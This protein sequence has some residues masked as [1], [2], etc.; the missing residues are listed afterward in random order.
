MELRS[1]RVGLLVVVLAM[2]AAAC[3]EDAT[4]PEGGGGTPSADTV[5]ASHDQNAGDLLAEICTRGEIR[6]STD[7]AYP[8][9]S[10]LNPET[11]EYEGF[12]IDVA[13]ESPTGSA[14]RSCGRRPSG[15]S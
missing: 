2:V 7:P 15:R 12:D 11:G 10:E 4:P 9:Q 8:P 6:V 3:G 13:T 1:V 14:S 5:C